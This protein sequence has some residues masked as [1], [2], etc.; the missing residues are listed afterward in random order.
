MHRISLLAQAMVIYLTAL[1]DLIRP[2]TVEF[3]PGEERLPPGCHQCTPAEVKTLLVDPFPNSQTRAVLYERW[4][5]VREAIR[6]VVPVQAEWLNGSYVTKKED[7]GDI[8]MISFLD[9]AVDQLD[10]ADQVLLSTLVAEDLSRDL[11]GC[12]SFPVIAYPEGH[13]GHS[14]YLGAKQTWAAFFG[15]DRDGNSKGYLE[16]V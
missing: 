4:L 11:H 13:P 5:A 10:A 6:R 1:Y 7:P 14:A 15:R 9:P 12:H 3:P 16:I 8:D 2:V